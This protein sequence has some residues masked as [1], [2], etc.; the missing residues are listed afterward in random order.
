VNLCFRSFESI[1][2]SL[3]WI[4]GITRYARKFAIDRPDVVITK[5]L[6]TSLARVHV[7]GAG[8]IKAKRALALGRQFATV[9]EWHVV[10]NTICDMPFPWQF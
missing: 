6:P 10:L 4:S 8:V 3:A 2:A 7:V 1:L 5:L 9:A